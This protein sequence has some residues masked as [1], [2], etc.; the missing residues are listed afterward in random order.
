VTARKKA[1]PKPVGKRSRLERE[2]DLIEEIA[3]LLRLGNYVG[4]VC[5]AVGIA[6]SS[7][8]AWLERGE[9]ALEK[10]EEARSL[11]EDPDAV[12]PTLVL[13]RREAR[14]AEFAEAVTR[15]DAR[16]EVTIAGIV[17]TSEDPRVLLEFLGRRYPARWGRQDKIE[18]TIRTIDDERIASAALTSEVARRAID[19]LIAEISGGSGDLTIDAGPFTISDE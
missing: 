1:A 10:V 11:A 12:D 14:Y 17:S 13:D 7:Y 8:Y 4:P 5:R 19:D 3:G 6:E 16:A 2:P 15:A 18:Q 9:A